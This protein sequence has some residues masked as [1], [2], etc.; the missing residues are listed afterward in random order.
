MCN[1]KWSLEVLV[2]ELFYNN[3]FSLELIIILLIS[4]NKVRITL[5]L[6]L[7]GHL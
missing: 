5:T 6:T 4:Q 7:D 2:V 1:L 3:I